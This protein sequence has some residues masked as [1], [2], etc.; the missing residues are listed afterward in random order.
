MSGFVVMSRDWLDHAVFYGDEFSRRD[1]WAW[2]IANAAWKPTKARLKGTT[3]ELERGELCFSVR[4]LA[5][6]WRW[7]KS[8]ADRWLHTLRAEGMI[9]TRSKTGAVAGQRAGQ[10][11]AIIFVRNYDKFQASLKGKR[12]RRQT[13][14][15]TTAGLQRDKE[16]QGNKGKDSMPDKSGDYAFLGQTIK[17]ALRH[18]NEWRRLFHT[19]PDIE[20]DLGTLDSWW[21]D[22]PEAKRKNWFL[23]TKGMLNKRHQQ[24]LKADKDAAAD[25]VWDGRP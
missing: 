23:A 14:T 7:S 17:L 18:L 24:N 13:E 12:D 3:V 15:G 25:S 20:A 6:K 19:I 11:P 5:R 16:E 1:A 2:L 9:A 21:Q 10:G 22:Q 8:R 4:F